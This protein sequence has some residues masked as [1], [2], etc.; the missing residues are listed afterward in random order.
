MTKKVLL[1]C[2]STPERVRRAV[3]RFPNDSVFQ[4]YELD[5]LCTTGDLPAFE[6][7]SQIR[8]RLVL[9]KRRQYAAAARLWAEVVRE[10]YAVVVVLWCMDPGKTPTKAFALLCLGRRILVFNENGDCAFL[11]PRFVWSFTQAR[12]RSGSFD[13][14]LFVQAL[15]SPLKHGVWG[16]LRLALFPIRLAVLLVSVGLLYLGKDSGQRR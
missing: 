2:S 14:S 5:L 10:R 12:I 8:R 16:L 6:K 7:W 1:V 11:S 15:V 9:P 13:N 3:E 4:H